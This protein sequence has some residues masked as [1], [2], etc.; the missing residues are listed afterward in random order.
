MGILTDATKT[1]NDVIQSLQDVHTD[2]EVVQLSLEEVRRLLESAE[3][4]L[5]VLADYE[6]G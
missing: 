4:Y 3:S 6:E 2:E 1:V 5:S